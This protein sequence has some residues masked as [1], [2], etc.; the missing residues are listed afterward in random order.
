LF[1]DRDIQKR[2]VCV[3]CGVDAA[4]PGT[5]GKKAIAMESFAKVKPPSTSI[6]Q[7]WAEERE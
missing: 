1:P 4:V 3:V 2:S 5:P 6:S 7:S